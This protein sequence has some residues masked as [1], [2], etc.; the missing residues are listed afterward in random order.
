MIGYGA[1]LLEGLV[2]IIALIAACSL[3]QE[4]YFAINVAAHKFLSLGMT[5]VN[6]DFLSREV[7]ESVAGRPGG[8][9]SLAVGFAQIFSSIPGMN[10]FMSYWYHFAIMF[11]AL[12]I[13][14][15]IDTGTRVARFLVQELLGKFYKPF[16]K[17]D[18]IPG[19][20]ISTSL[21]VF[22]WS[23]LIH[24]GS[25]S[26]IWPMFGVANQLLAG[27]AL[28]VASSAI[29]NA[30]KQ[31]LVWVTLLPLSFVSVTTLSAGFLNITG[32]FLPL[33]KNPDTAFQG[34]LNSL[35]T[36]LIMSCSVIILIDSGRRWHRVL[37]KKE[38]FVPGGDS[39]SI[40][41]NLNPPEYGCC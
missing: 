10:R 36:A 20:M 28:C 32:N 14:T 19:T 39:V 13:L 3:Y 1:M 25:I 40:R 12:F 31:K 35:L 27:V 6:L 16:E 26:T 5:P 24:T 29:I 38:R 4:D 9:V 21:I 34:Y 7:G 2:G 17:T 15:T 41:G 18:W 30:G 37:A 33:T 8:A 11:E 23:Y 22:S